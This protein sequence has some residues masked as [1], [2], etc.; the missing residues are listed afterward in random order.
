MFYNSNNNN[1]CYKRKI[2]NYARADF[3]KF[4]EILREHDLATQ[5]QHTDIDTGVQQI[6]EAVFDAASKSVP[7]KTITIRPN[8]HPWITCHIKNLIRKRKRCHKKF[9]KTANIHYWD[10]YKILRNTTIN[11]IRRSKKDYYDKLEDM[12]TSENPN[13]KLFWKTSKQLL[14]IGKISQNVPTL[15]LND[16]FAET[17]LQKAEMLNK[18]FASQSYVNDDNKVLPQ[19]TDVLHDPLYLFTITPQNTKDV[20]DNLDA[21]KSCGPDLMS[22]R[23]LKEGSSILATPYSILF[24]SSLQQ[25]E[26]PSQWKEANVTC[27]HKKDDRSLP[28]NYRPISLLCQAGKVMERCVHKELYNYINT[29]NL[30]TPFQSGFVPGDS[31]TLQL[32]HTYHTFCEAVD[33]GKEVR[34]VFCDISKAFDRVWHRGLLYKLSHMGCS[35]SILKWFSSFLTDRRQRVVINGQASQWTFVKAGVP[36]GSILGPLLFLVYINDIVNDLNASVRLFADDTSLYIIVENPNTAAVT[37]NN[38]LKH[39]SNWANDWLV[40]FNPSKTFSMLISRKRDSVNHPTLFMNNIPLK[41]MSTHK[42][43]GLTFSDTC[44]WTNHITNITDAACSR[45]NLLRT[46]KFKINRRAL[47]KIYFA[48]IRPVLEYSDSVWDNATTDS[49][50]QLEAIHLEAARIITGATKLC[51]TEKLLSDLGWD[52][53]QNRRNKHKLT[54]LYKILN[55]LTPEYLQFILPPLVQNTTNYNLRNSNNL[56]S[57]HANTNLFYNSFFPSTIRAWNDL[58]EDIKNSPSVAA[59]KYRLNRDTHPPPK[60]FNA[61]T[62]MGQI[63]HARIRMECSALNSHLYRK[64]IV[65]SPSCSCGDFESAYHFFFICPNYSNARN[66]YLPSNLN[67]L[68]THQLLHGK[69]DVSDSDNECLFLQVQDFI[70]HSRRFI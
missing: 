47:E 48:F 58:S 60:Y 55:G 52:S 32:I 3:D 44:D 45:L 25:G 54:I 42:H 41:C 30:L 43:L 29:H 17:D 62:R 63:L 69:P 12:L 1:N 4:R 19:P 10:K 57:I 8:D 64:N 67:D 5:I 59:F 27:I 49:K 21:S 26:F 61:G 50:K 22:P 39:I 56:R 7:N 66:L 65:P 53:L 37:L 24:N 28:S 18:Y 11:E 70:M 6:T 13:S 20:L 14:K 16:E 36:Q 35:E 9:K 23:L 68:N 51:S 34:V 38:D 33:S 31:T 2:W 40:D 15:K 46:L